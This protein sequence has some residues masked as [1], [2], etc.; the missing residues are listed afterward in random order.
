MV[1]TIEL[2]PIFFHNYRYDILISLPDNSMVMT[3]VMNMNMN[4]VLPALGRSLN[5]SDRNEVPKD[6]IGILFKILCNR[7]GNKDQNY[8]MEKLE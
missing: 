8:L 4:M 6:S 1:R 7:I 2:I 5:N 3:M